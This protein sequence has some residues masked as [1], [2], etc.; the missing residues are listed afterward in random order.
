[1]VDLSTA[2]YAIGLALLL[3]FAGVLLYR[4]LERK[5]NKLEWV[6]LIASSGKLNAYKIGYWIGAGIGG[7]VVVKQ[8]LSNSLDAG[9]FGVWL[10]FLAGISVANSYM[11]RRQKSHKVDDPDK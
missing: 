1:M 2:A 4:L 8:T 6:D 9:V 11:S 3:A 5:D 10:G 7:W